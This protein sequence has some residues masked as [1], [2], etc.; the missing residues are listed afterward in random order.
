MINKIFRHSAW[1][2]FLGFIIAAV[3]IRSSAPAFPNAGQIAFSAVS[4]NRQNLFLVDVARDIQ[5]T[6]GSGADDYHALSWSDDGMRF[7][8]A[9]TLTQ[10][11]RLWLTDFNSYDTNRLYPDAEN[12]AGTIN[13]APVWSASNAQLAYVYHDAELGDITLLQ[14]LVNDPLQTNTVMDFPEEATITGYTDSTIQWIEITRGEV[15]LQ[16]LDLSSNEKRT[17][18]TWDFDFMRN[19]EPV[20]SPDGTQFIISG[21]TSR[22]LDYELYL[23]DLNSDEVINLSNRRNHNDTNPAWSPDG[24]SFAYKS[25]NGSVDLII[26]QLLDG[27]HQQV[28]HSDADARISQLHWSPD[29]QALAFVS[30]APLVYSLC[31]LHLD[32]EVLSCPIVTRKISELAW[33]PE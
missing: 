14:S 19:W 29:G 15:R 20:P 32:D 12:M 28:V 31:V 27:T 11:D 7:A 2:G 3:L 21:F 17:I 4:N 33:R 22:A 13:A 5:H 10:T 8:F 25:L 23:F 30:N 24:K 1:I 18:R 9:E 26:V 6:L 16:E